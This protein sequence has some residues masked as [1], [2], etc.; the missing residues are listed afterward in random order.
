MQLEQSRPLS[1][2]SIWDTWMFVLFF[3]VIWIIRS[4]TY[5]AL[6]CM[7]DCERNQAL[8]ILGWKTI[9][10]F[11]LPVFY[12]WRVDQVNPFEYLRLK[13]NLKTNLYCML[14]LIAIGGIWQFGLLVSRLDNSFPNGYDVLISI[15]GAGVCEEV[16][17]R[18]FFLRKF[19]QF[20][21]SNKA[22]AVT[23]GLFVLA[24]FPGWLVYGGNAFNNMLFSGLY[25]FV[26]SII[27]SLMV[28]RTKCLYPS[29]GFHIIADL[30]AF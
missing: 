4:L 10:W 17:F 27:L 24:H 26:I 1:A 25:I 2:R 8:L 30:I 21:G 5:P 6:D 7:M 20:M 23:S 22:I 18:G 11:L 19:S 14:G 13:S 16:L 29:I 12:L 3:F 15:W 9:V 28:K